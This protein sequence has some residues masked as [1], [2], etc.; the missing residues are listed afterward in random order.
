MRGPACVMDAFEGLVLCSSGEHERG[1]A[2]LRDGRLADAPL[3]A[4]VRHA[5]LASTPHWSTPA[6]VKKD[7]LRVSNALRWSAE[8]LVAGELFTEWA[9]LLTTCAALLGEADTVIKRNALLTTAHV[10]SQHDAGRR[11]AAWHSGARLLAGLL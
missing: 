10:L 2:L 3:A 9:A 5:L 7:A 4:L 6:A 8:Q 11:V 1:E